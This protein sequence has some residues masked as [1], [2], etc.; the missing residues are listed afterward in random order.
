MCGLQQSMCKDVIRC[1]GLSDLNLSGVLMDFCVGHGCSIMSTMFQHVAHKC[2]WYQSTLSQWLMIDFDHLIRG[3]MS[4][5]LGWT[6]V[7]CYQLITTWWCVGSSVVSGVGG[8]R[9]CY[10]EGLLVGL[11]RSLL[12]TM[13]VAQEAKSGLSPDCVAP[14]RRTAD[15][16]WRY[17]QAMEKNSLNSWTLPPCLV[18]VRQSMRTQTKVSSISLAEVTKSCPEGK[19][20]QGQTKFTLRCGSL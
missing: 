12:Q 16:D 11:L 10:G 13:K 7:H 18:R 15:P 20:H 3:C 14:R 17:C 2:T 6:E 5:T 8:V 4:W 9:R 19:E 1:I